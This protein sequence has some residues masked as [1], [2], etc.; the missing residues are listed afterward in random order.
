[1]DE[2]IL[3]KLALGFSRPTMSPSS[4]HLMG[5]AN[6]FCASGSPVFVGKIARITDQV[7]W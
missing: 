2:W 3:Q 7:L 6:H 5:T 4:L 1:M